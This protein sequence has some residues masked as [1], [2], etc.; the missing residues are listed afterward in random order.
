MVGRERLADPLE[1]GARE[2]D[3]IIRAFDAAA[4]AMLISDAEGTICFVN[5]AFTKITG[6]SKYEVAGLNPR[7]LKSGRQDVGYYQ[8]MWGCLIENGFWEDKIWNK[9]KDGVIYPEHLSIS[10]I[11]DGNG[12]C[13]HYVAVFS[14][15]TMRA[16]FGG[17]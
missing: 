3:L 11:Y 16:E 12:I 13:S 2:R 1:L 7:V 9:R 14:D 17:R 6:W 8:D 4:V 10:A 5:P 15:V